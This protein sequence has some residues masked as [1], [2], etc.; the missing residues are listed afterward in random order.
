MRVDLEEIIYAMDFMDEGA[1]AYYHKKSEI[2]LSI[3]QREYLAAKTGVEIDN[4][5]E[6]QQEAVKWAYDIVENKESYIKLPDKL[7][8]DDTTILKLFIKE[9]DESVREK[10]EADLSRGKDI[11]YIRENYSEIFDGEAW[12]EYKDNFFISLAKDWCKA[13]NIIFN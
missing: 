12:Y 1:G 2:V 7:E 5:P 13:N 8:F 6:W 10:I 11:R 4:Y 3:S 9:I